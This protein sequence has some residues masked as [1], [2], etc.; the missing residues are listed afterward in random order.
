[1]LLLLLLLLL[2]IDRE[3]C[4]SLLETPL[5]SMLRLLLSE[6]LVA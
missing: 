3:M 4:D 2:H 1:M 5:S 6:D